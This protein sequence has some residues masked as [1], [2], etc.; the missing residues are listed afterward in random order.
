MFRSAFCCRTCS[1]PNCSSPSDTDSLSQGSSVGSLGPE[2]DEDRNSLKNHFESLASS[3]AE[4][5]FDTDLTALRPAQEKPFLNPRLSISTRFLSRFQDRLRSIPRGPAPPECPTDTDVVLMCSRVRP[6]RIT[7]RISEE[8]NS[9]LKT[10]SELQMRSEPSGAIGFPGSTRGE[11]GDRGSVCVTAVGGRAVLSSRA[12]CGISHEPRRRAARR[13]HTVL[14]LRCK[15]TLG[16]VTSRTANSGA[17]SSVTEESRLAY[18]DI[19]KPGCCP[20]E[21]NKENQQAPPAP[22]QAPP[23]PPQAPPRS[24]Q[25]Q[26]SSPQVLATPP[27]VTSRC[28]GSGC[29][30][31]ILDETPTNPNRTLIQSPAPPAPP[32]GL[33]GAEPGSPTDPDIVAAPDS[34]VFAPP[35]SSSSPMSERLRPQADSGTCLTD[36]EG[37]EPVSLQRC[38]QA[39]IALRQAT[40]RAVLLYHQVCGSE[41][42][43]SCSVLQ[44]AAATAHRELQAVLP[45]PCCGAPSGQTQDE[46]T[47]SLLEKYSELLVQMTQNKLNKI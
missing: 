16:D 9:N 37:A 41:R 22:P 25:E 6:G 45:A 35:T 17:A 38:Q 33:K 46:Q 13:R 24:Q 34:S 36:E 21:E 47:M 8:S 4:E 18:L 23:A 32:G 29:S 11:N 27:A 31:G 14:V 43:E 19:S 40:Q 28:A 2:D 7:G 42:S 10:G 1:D 12:S 5:R 20:L 15:K 39:A 44:E 30:A 26:S 3:L